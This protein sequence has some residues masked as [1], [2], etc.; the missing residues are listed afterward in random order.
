MK[1]YIVMRG[2]NHEGLMADEPHEVYLA[3]D[4]A[5]HA[6]DNMPWERSDYGKVVELSLPPLD[7]VIRW[8]R[9]QE[10]IAGVFRE[11]LGETRR[12]EVVREG[13]GWPKPDPHGLHELPDAP[14][15]YVSRACAAAG[16]GNNVQRCSQPHSTCDAWSGVLSEAND[17]E[18][19]RCGDTW[20]DPQGSGWRGD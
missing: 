6:A 4:A 15:P 9:S 8:T 10:F 18:Q 14:E 11:A 1:A 19:L 7:T 3:R 17:P 13:T 2:F 20:S 16:C 12:V 5:E